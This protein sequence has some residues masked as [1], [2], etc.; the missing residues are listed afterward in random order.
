M[1]AFEMFPDLLDGFFSR[2]GP[3]FRLCAGAEPV[4]ARGACMGKTTFDLT[5]VSQVLA[6]PVDQN[7]QARGAT[8]TPADP[9]IGTSTWTVT[10]TS[11]SSVDQPVV[12]MFTNVDVSDYPDVQTGLDGNLS[13]ILRQSVGSDEFLYP[14]VSL[15]SLAAGASVQF[16]VRYI[17]N[18]ELPFGPDL[19]PPEGPDLVM[20]PLR[21]LGVVVPEPGTAALF[22]TGLLGLAARRRRQRWA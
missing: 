12:L 6:L 14:A 16:Q 11:G 1:R 3:D 7:P 22:A 10:N 2:G 21:L 20:P 19:V 4:M 15:G 18:G 9:F 5:V 13:G 8:P 17:V